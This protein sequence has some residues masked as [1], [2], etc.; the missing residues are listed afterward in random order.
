MSP[1]ARIAEPAGQLPGSVALT[2]FLAEPVPPTSLASRYMLVDQATTLLDG[3]YV[4]LRLKR[5]MYGLDPVQRLRL[6]E[7]RLPALTDLQFH[8]ELSAIFRS[9]R[10]LH[11]TYQLPSRYRGQ[12]AALGIL[13]EH[14]HDRVGEQRYLATRIHPALQ[15][16]SFTAGVEIVDW[17]GMPIE[18]A[19]ELNAEL[20]AGSNPDAR[21]ARGLEAL[22][23]RP[24][25]SSPPPD[26]RWVILGYRTRNGR[27]GEIRLPWRVLSPHAQA[28]RAQDPV[29]ALVLVHGIDPASEAVRQL[30]RRLFAPAKAQRAQAHALVSVLSARSRRIRGRSVGYLRLFSFNVSSARRFVEQ[31]SAILAKLPADGLIIDIRA[32]P[33]GNI[34]AAEGVLQLLTAETVEPSRFSLATTPLALELSQSNPEFQRGLPVSMTPSRPGRPTPSRCRSATPKRSPP[35]CRATR[36]PSC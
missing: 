36:A 24:L 16:G 28:G 17:N 30:K 27:D 12:V 3:L 13:V 10:D 11:T 20:H 15:K 33:G 31:L 6:L 34:P 7:R 9:V 1:Q 14:Y 32:N 35:D 5:A 22:T 8:T 18:R 26:E 2:E 19:V 21:L 25:S 4:H 29:S 23:V